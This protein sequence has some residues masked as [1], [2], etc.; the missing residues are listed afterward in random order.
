LASLL[1]REK[2]PVLGAPAVQRQRVSARAT[3]RP[4]PGLSTAAV[5]VS[6]AAARLRTLLRRRPAAR[7]PSQHTRAAEDAVATRRGSRPLVDAAPAAA[8]SPS[9]HAR[10]TEDAAATRRGSRPLADAAPAAAVAVRPRESRGG[11]GRDSPGKPS[12][13]R[14]R[15]RQ[16]RRRAVAVRPRKS[17]GGRG[18]DSPGKPL[19]HYTIRRDPPSAH[20][21]LR[22][23]VPQSRHDQG[24]QQGS[25]GAA[26]QKGRSSKTR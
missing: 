23:R 19:R 20:R 3:Q 22:R 1:P 18:R 15:P 8:P 4:P 12:A 5:A 24:S 7:E 2:E 9:G 25:E 16:R 26:I 11:R 13:R 10:A 17:R 6:S 14:R 21:R